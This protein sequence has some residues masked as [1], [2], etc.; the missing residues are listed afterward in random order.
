[1]PIYVPLIMY[2]LR[3]FLLLY[4]NYIVYETFNMTLRWSL[5][6]SIGMQS[7]VP[8][9]CPVIEVRESK[10]KKNNNNSNNKEKMKN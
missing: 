6:S 2:G 10:L 9:L 8:Q 5:W 1:M 4:K 7:L 3:L